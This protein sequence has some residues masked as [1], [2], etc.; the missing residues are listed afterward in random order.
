MTA[1][2]GIDM[3]LWDIKGKAAGMPLYQLLGGRSR[4]GVTLYAHASGK[5]TEE[6]L[7]EAKKLVEAG[8]KAIRIQSAIPGLE[9][10]D[11]VIGDMKDYY[12][13]QGKPA[14]SSRGRV[15]NPKVFRHGGRIV[16]R[17]ATPSRK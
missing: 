7:G 1:I 12:E 13:M 2:G 3:A 9:A 4:T 5:N 14:S 6:T 11:G 17:S 8:F 16:S 10:T 15:V